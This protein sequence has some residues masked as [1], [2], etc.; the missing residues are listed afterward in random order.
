MR[1]MTT[2]ATDSAKADREEGP[3]DLVIISH[4]AFKTMLFERIGKQMT[5]KL[6][7]RKAMA[8]ASLTE[9]P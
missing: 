1:N 2:K 8:V 4:E 7:K 9:E 5:G 3:E 6:K